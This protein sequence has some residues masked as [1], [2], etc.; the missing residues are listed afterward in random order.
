MKG[1]VQKEGKVSICVLWEEAHD[2]SSW[3]V[4]C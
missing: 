1:R 3:L 2:S 4:P